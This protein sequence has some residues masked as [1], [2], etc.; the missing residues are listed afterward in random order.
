MDKQEKEQKET[1]NHKLKVPTFSCFYSFNFVLVKIQSILLFLSFYCLSLFSFAQKN[2]LKV[3]SWN[4]FLR[5]GILRDNQLERTKGIGVYL[6]HSDA[7]VIILQEVFHKKSRVEL[8]KVLKGIYPNHT[9]RGPLSFFGVS[10]GVLIFSKLPLLEEHFGSFKSGTGSDRLAKK[11][12]VQTAINWYGESIGI[13]GT[14]LQA[15]TS[16]RC[17]NTRKEQIIE[18]A[19]ASKRL[20]ASSPILFG[21]DFNLKSKGEMFG[22]LT[23]TLDIE[24][25]ELESKIKY[26]A[27]F[28]DQDLFPHEGKSVWIDFILLRRTARMIQAKVWIEEPK[29]IK[30]GIMTRISDHNPVLS[31]FRPIEF[32]H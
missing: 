10:L 20:D 21:G 23:K 25:L 5:P 7:D 18:I 24:E 4:V 15:G 3:L 6:L 12:F 16:L 26:S 14:H 22:F 32:E 27:N 13:F 2:E 29:E 11:G 8:I 28:S 19:N 17:M 9:S 30:S 31:L 1:F